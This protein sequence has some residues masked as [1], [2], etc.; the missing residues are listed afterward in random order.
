MFTEI[1][2]RMFGATGFFA[3]STDDGPAINRMFDYVRALL[4]EQGMMR[5][6]G[7]VIN[8]SGA[9][10][11]ATPINATNIVA[12]SLLINGGLLIGECTGKP[13]MDLVGSRGYSLNNVAFYGSKTNRPSCAYQ[14][15]RPSADGFCDN[16]SFVEVSTTGW[17]SR[18]AIHCYGHETAKHDHCT[19]FNYDHTARVAIFE[20]FNGTPFTSDYTTV[21]SGATSFINNKL[22]SCD[23][24]YVPIDENVAA[25]T[26]VTVAASGVITAPGHQFA[27]NDQVVFAYVGGMP[28]MSKLIATVTAVTINTITINQSTVGLGAYTGGGA[29]IRRQSYPSVYLSRAQQFNFDC[30]YI[31]AY[32]REHLELDFPD[33]SKRRMEHLDLDILFEGS[34]NNSNLLW[35][36]RSS[37]CNVQGIRLKTYNGNA[38]CA[39]F[40]L[41]PGGALT[42]YGADLQYVTPL[43]G[44]VPIA[45]G[46]QEAALAIFGGN[47]VCTDLSQIPHNGLAGFKGFI[48]AIVTGNVYSR[49]LTAL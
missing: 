19:Y 30:C 21:M 46:G 28:N 6:I 5:N 33:S 23:F 40:G 15:A 11:V 1:T 26:G 37:A 45:G 34:G 10:S 14:L 20:G 13:I 22:V 7:L 31:V 24:R 39:W 4:A 41:Y 47:I 42:L 35:N 3:G 25:I 29:V 43:Y 16:N 12:W 9:W 38:A 36:T 32:G 8:L 18:A 17:F 44:T 48:T 27:V 49:G 2:P